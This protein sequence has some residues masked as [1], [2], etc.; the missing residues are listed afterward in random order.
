[1]RL[2]CF[3]VPKE[4]ILYFNFNL[5]TEVNWKVVLSFLLFFYFF[6]NMVHEDIN[7]TDGLSLHNLAHNVYS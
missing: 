4:L 7:A 5:I 2:I 1:M 3:L 6:F